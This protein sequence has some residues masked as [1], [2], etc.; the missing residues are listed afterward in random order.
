MGLR[1]SASKKQAKSEVKNNTN[2][3]IVWI[4]NTTDDKN[5]NENEE[6]KKSK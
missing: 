6:M 5:E 1:A 2:L 3:F 4:L